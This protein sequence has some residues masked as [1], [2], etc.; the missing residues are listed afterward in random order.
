[1]MA[2]ESIFQ[3]LRLRTPTVKKRGSGA[4]VTGR[5]ENDEDAQCRAPVSTIAEIVSVSSPSTSL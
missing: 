2:F 5:V 4:T 3:S 1:M